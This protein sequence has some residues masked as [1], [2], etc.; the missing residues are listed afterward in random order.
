MKSLSNKLIAALIIII[1]VSSTAIAIAS[2][3]VISNSTPNM[4]PSESP[5]SITA[6]SA[7]TNNYCNV[8]CVIT[9]LGVGSDHRMVYLKDLTIRVGANTQ[10]ELSGL[11]IYLN[12]KIVNESDF[13]KQPISYGASVQDSFIIPVTAADQW[14]GSSVNLYAETI[15]YGVSFPSCTYNRVL[16]LN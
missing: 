10:D 8:S 3:G 5:L 16:T 12:G 4:G 6:S 1:I 2:S 13:Y 15:G 11:T 7:R 9:N 14:A